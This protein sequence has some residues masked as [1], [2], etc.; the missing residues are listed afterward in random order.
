MVAIVNPA[1]AG[2][3]KYFYLFS[4]L[5]SKIIQ[6]DRETL[7]EKKSACI[8]FAH[9]RIMISKVAYIIY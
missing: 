2:L 4:K 9:V 6:T 5:V 1:R 3:R 8:V 7:A